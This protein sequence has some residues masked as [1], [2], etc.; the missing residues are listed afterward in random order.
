MKK[1]TK[2]KKPK[3]KSVTSLK[4]KLWTLISQYIRQKYADSDGYASCVTCGDT[5]HWKELQ[6][7]HYCPSGASSYLRYVESNIH[8]Q[9]Y[10]C[11]INLG[12]NPIEY[13][14]FM[15]R[16]YWE[17]FVEQMLSMRN[18]PTSLKDYDLKVLTEDYQE[19]LNNLNK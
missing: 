3:K 10:R 1:I 9:C 4:K 13:R 12:S 11:N 16:T 6:A 17:T 2:L 8:P 15:V 18:E 14:E 19:R 5:K 7:G